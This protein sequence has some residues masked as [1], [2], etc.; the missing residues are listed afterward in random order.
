MRPARESL[1]PTTTRWILRLIAALLI[2]ASV[3]AAALQGAPSSA[4]MQEARAAT[5]DT[6]EQDAPSL[7]T[8]ER[9]A[10]LYLGAPVWTA[11]R[12]IAN[13]VRESRS[14]DVTGD[15]TVWPSFFFGATPS[16][17][18]SSRLQTLEAEEFGLGF[19]ASFWRRRSV[20]ES[21]DISAPSNSQP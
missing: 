12:R 3:G 16:I 4:S 11:N 5:A 6:L 21:S 14:A 19:D 20:G 17:W 1:V 13:G 9:L 15:E 7:A 8:A 2:T 10:A 18:D